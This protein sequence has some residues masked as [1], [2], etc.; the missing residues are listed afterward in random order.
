MSLSAKIGFFFVA[1]FA[2]AALAL[3]SIVMAQGEGLLAMVLFVVA[4]ILIFLGI[5]ARRKLLKR[6][7]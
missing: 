4:F 1:L 3:A 6:P 7:S 5:R 2:M